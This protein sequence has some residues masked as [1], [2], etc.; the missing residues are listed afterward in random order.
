[1]V[2]CYVAG[3]SSFIM[4]KGSLSVSALVPCAAVWVENANSS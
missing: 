2:V 1:M 3:T 4:G